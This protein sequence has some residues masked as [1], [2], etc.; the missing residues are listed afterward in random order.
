MSH[1][2]QATA[3]LVSLSV[4]TAKIGERYYWV[5]YTTE[6]ASAEADTRIADGFAKTRAHAVL[7]AAAVLENRDPGG[8][9]YRE[10]YGLCTSPRLR[11]ALALWGGHWNK[12]RAEIGPAW[13]AAQLY[14][15]HHGRTLKMRRDR[16]GGTDA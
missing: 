2:D 7:A 6:S 15:R 3:G 12:A 14:R 9:G 11:S 5:V 8:A 10:R 16:P 4:A 13:I 1:D